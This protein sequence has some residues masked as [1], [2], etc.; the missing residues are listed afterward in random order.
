M[1]FLNR[2]FRNKGHGVGIDS[3]AATRCQLMPVGAST[4]LGSG[5]SIVMGVPHS[6]MVDFMDNPKEKL[7]MTGGTPVL[8]NPH[9]KLKTGLAGVPYFL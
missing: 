4:S 5:V 3:Q 7:M 1:V 6:W 9:I 8:G 2:G